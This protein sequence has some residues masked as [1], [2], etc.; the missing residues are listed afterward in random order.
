MDKMGAALHHR[1]SKE[2]ERISSRM[3]RLLQT[4]YL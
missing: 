3:N 2:M 4:A 1:E